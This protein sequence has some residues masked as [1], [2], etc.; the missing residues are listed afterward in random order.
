MA[1]DLKL[2]LKR[3]IGRY[4]ED[5][6]TVSPLY[7][8]ALDRNITLV[9]RIR[10]R[11]HLLTCNACTNYVQNISMMRDIFRSHDGSADSDHAHA[12]LSPDAKERIKSALKSGK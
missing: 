5:C 10:I 6:K 7:S 12:S 3:W 1:M 2:K 4:A 8:Y 9:E 11:F